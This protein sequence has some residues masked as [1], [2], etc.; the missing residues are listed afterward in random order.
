[1]T[2]KCPV[3]VTISQRR[4][5]QLLDFDIDYAANLIMILCL[6][7]C[8]QVR[9][10]QRPLMLYCPR[11]LAKRGEARSVSGLPLSGIQGTF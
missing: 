11:I 9:Y 8:S 1:M 7:S 10:Q 6:D 2:S 5:Q 3:I 4:A